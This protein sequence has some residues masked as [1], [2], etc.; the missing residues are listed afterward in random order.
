[1]RPFGAKDLV[2]TT[3]RAATI[4]QFKILVDHVGAFN[5]KEY[6]E[7]PHDYLSWILR[8]GFGFDQSDSRENAGLLITGDESVPRDQ[9]LEAIFSTRRPTELPEG[10]LPPH[11]IYLAFHL[12]TGRLLAITGFVP[13]I[14]QVGADLGLAESGP[15][16][17]LG[18][19]AGD[20]VS[21]NHRG[22]G[23]DLLLEEYRDLVIQVYVDST[24]KPAT[25]YRLTKAN[26]LSNEKSFFPK[27]K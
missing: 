17:W 23:A 10:Y 5:R 4:G 13:D 6:Y 2:F 15:P 18:F 27:L 19:F 25:V 7:E 14:R 16:S 26:S 9:E 3:L 11:D 20:Y 21:S 22:R 24:G 12:R 1:M 8:Y